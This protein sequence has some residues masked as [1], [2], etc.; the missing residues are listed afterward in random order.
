MASRPSP[1]QKVRSFGEDENTTCDIRSISRRS[2][3][4]DESSC[5]PPVPSLLD[6]ANATRMLSLAQ[7]LARA[8]LIVGDLE[9]LSTLFQRGCPVLDAGVGALAEAD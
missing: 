1:S 9:L 7:A 3:L 5:R 2:S 8:D 6:D 4:N